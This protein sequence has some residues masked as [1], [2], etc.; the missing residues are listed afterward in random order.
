MQHRVRE[1]IRQTCSELG[2]EIIKGV[3]SKDHVHMFISVPPQHA[4]SD[5]MRRIKGRSSRRIQQEFPAI[6]KRYWGCHFWARGYFSAT[7]GTITDDV[8][9]QYLDNHITEPTD[10]S[11]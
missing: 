10:V 9:L 7:S 1:I 3:L 8:I 5:V 4:L 6:K 11:R 2:I